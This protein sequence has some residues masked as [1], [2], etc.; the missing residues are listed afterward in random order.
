MQLFWIVLLQLEMSGKGNEKPWAK[1]GL[2]QKIFSHEKW[3][4]GSRSNKFPLTE[5]TESIWLEMYSSDVLQCSLA[6]WNKLHY[7]RFSWA[8]PL[9]LN[10]ASHTILATM[11][12]T[13]SSVFL[14]PVRDP[15]RHFEAPH[16]LGSARSRSRRDLPEGNCQ[17][18]SS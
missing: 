9:S 18:P 4:N 7:F 1:L 14:K 15:H 16:S 3:N 13:T 8:N 6:M 5:S 11:G 17:F 10:T 2:K 12:T